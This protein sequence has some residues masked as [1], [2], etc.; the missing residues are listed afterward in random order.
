MDSERVMAEL[1]AV[2]LTPKL[3]QLGG[4]KLVADWISYILFVIALQVNVNKP[5]ACCADWITGG[6]ATV[7]VPLTRVTV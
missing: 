2:T 3:V 5:P 4:A 6:M 1:V 7:N